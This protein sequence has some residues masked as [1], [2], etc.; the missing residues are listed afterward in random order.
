MALGVSG[1]TWSNE[2]DANPPM[3]DTKPPGGNNPRI[4]FV[5]Q[6]NTLPIRTN[7][8]S[9]PLNFVV[10]TVVIQCCVY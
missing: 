4:F 9:V 3:G 8:M 1:T 2:N 10:N 5:Y 7:I 6:L